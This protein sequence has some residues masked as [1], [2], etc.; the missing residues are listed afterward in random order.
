LVVF[1]RGKGLRGPQS[2]GLLLG[3]KDLI[4]AAR[5]NNNPNSDSLCRTNKVNKEELV[6]MLLALEL[7][8]GR[9][10]DAVWKEWE[11]RCSRITQTLAEFKD[12]RTEVNVPAVANAVPHLHVSWD[13]EKRKLSP[14]QMMDTLRDGEPSIEVNP[15]SRREL[16]IGVW[17]MEPGE[18]LI[19]ARRIRQILASA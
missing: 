12:V 5:L 2:S 6:G 9:D 4:A 7:F 14:A 13:Y 18:D 3:R 19:V 11:A 17:M 10:H 1:S 8:L 16:I 15:D